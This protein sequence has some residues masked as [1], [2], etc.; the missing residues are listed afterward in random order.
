MLIEANVLNGKVVMTSMDI[1]NHLDQRVVAR[2]LRRSILNYMKS[3]DFRP[4]FTVEP[5]RISDL[6][7]KIAPPVDMFTN[8]SPDELKPKI[9]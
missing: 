1:T 7:E 3:D 5:G 2:Q 6:F 9:N 4:A 8:D